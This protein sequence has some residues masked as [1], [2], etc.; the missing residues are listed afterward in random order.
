MDEPGPVDASP[1]GEIIPRDLHSDTFHFVTKAFL[2]LDEVTADAAPY[3]YC[4]GSNRLNLRRI[5]WEYRNSVRPEQYASPF[6][7]YNRVNADEMAAL[8]L[9]PKPF[10]APPNTLILTNTF[11]LHLRGKFRKKGG[12][13][14]VL[15]LDFRSNPF[16]L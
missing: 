16:R 15:R 14:R 9:S 4:I 11:G 3:T 8:K 6:E 7:Y 13:R 12:T 2:T 1:D 5:A 10:P